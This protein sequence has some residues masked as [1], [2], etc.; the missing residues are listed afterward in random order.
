[1]VNRGWDGWD[2]KERRGDAKDNIGSK[3][4]YNFYFNGESFFDFCVPYKLS[5]TILFST[6]A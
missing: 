2:E 3:L 6:L 4:I 5:Y 1:M